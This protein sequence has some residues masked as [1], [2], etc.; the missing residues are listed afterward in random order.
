MKR[1][2]TRILTLAAAACLAVGC[3]R[4]GAAPPGRD[5]DGGAGGSGSSGGSS[6]NGGMSGGGG[7]GT[8]GHGTI[9]DM[10]GAAP[11][12]VVIT[13]LLENHD[14][15]EVVGNAADAPFINSLIERYG[16]ATN[17]IDSKVHPSLP[18]YLY[19]ISGSTQGVTSDYNAGSKPPFKADN[20]GDQMTTAGI[21][22][23]SYSEDM[24]SACNLSDG[25]RYATRH[26]PFLYFDGVR[27]GPNG[28]CAS[29]QVDYKSFSADLAAGSYKYMWI[30]P[31]LFNDGH[32]GPLPIPFF[33][34]P[35]KDLQT[36]DNWLAAELPAILESDVFKAGGVLFLT[37][38]EAE[39]RN[40]D[41]KDQIPMIVVSPRLKSKGRTLD[42][43][44]SHASYLATVE[45]IFG[46]PRL[47]EAQGA[48]TLLSL[49]Q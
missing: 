15:K 18:N 49:L 10:G 25:F 46:L 44:T 45:D 1:M 47:G 24:G 33:D 27:N 37:W 5:S 23:R 42:V 17:Y 7:T 39:G 6:G 4:D 30:T 32:G 26:D 19:L 35:A 14:Y 48:T 38:D 9:G 21:A 43:A 28:Q 36:S 20:L 16:L 12:T 31:N 22:W 11:F 13:I 2:R 40:K 8:G 41:D 34:D 3:V 29:T